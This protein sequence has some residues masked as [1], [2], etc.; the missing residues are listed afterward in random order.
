MKAYSTDLREKIALA[1]EHHDYT[2]DDVAELFAVGRR[3]VARFVQKRRAGLSLAPQPHAGGYPTAL[4]AETLSTLRDKVV[5]TP[6]ATLSELVSYLKTEARVQV[7]PSTVCRAL[8]RLGLPRKKRRSLPTNE[9]KQNASPSGGGW[10]RWIAAS[11]S[12]LMKR[13]FTWLL[14]VPSGA[15]RAAS[16]SSG[17]CRLSAGRTIR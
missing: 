8:Q 3:T 6:D 13:A 10:P 1:Y 4:T 7:H 14:R 17:V 12:L 11:W 15:P 9:T 5:E 16:A 2:L